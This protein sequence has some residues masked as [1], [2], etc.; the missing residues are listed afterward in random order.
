MSRKD[1]ATASF[2]RS[3]NPRLANY[4]KPGL[5]AALILA[6]TLAVTGVLFYLQ[7]TGC[8]T[9][10]TT[11][12][13]LT[14]GDMSEQEDVFRIKH[15]QADAST[16]V[17]ICL[18]Y[19]KELVTIG[20]PNYAESLVGA[21]GVVRYVPCSLDSAAMQRFGMSEC[22]ST[23]SAS[24]ACAGASPVAC[25]PCGDLVGDGS[26][27]G[28]GQTLAVDSLPGAPFVTYSETS[29]AHTQCPTYGTALGAALGYT[30]YLE[31]LFTI[32]FVLSLKA[33]K[34]V[35]VVDGGAGG[36]G[37]LA[38]ASQG[39]FVRTP[40][41]IFCAQPRTSVRVPA[42]SGISQKEF[43]GMRGQLVELQKQLAESVKQAV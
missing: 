22:E 19:A 26:R 37:S 2:V 38:A 5:L 7:I 29:L 28:E 40:T 12:V 1:Q 17:S 31:L 8:P 20:H 10:V 25:R 15:E 41:L 14:F 21:P 42:P 11:T 39:V 4:S 32:G 33:C 23:T 24:E 13:D 35:E 18:K 27:L 16:T 30:S 9:R 43:E 6:A 36:L 34:V 3:V